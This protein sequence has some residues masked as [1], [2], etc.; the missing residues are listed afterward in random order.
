MGAVHLAKTRGIQPRGQLRQRHVD[1]ED[2]LR[3]VDLGVVALGL[4]PPDPVRRDRNDAVAVAREEARERARSERVAG[5]LAGG[6][7]SSFWARSP[8]RARTRA[9]AAASRSRP[10][11]LTR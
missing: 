3:G 1:Q 9:T 10:K 6:G 7:S 4:D 8:S 5:A 2:A 11:G